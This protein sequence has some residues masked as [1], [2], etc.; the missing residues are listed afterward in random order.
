MVGSLIDIEVT[1]FALRADG[2]FGGFFP[3]VVGP[4]LLLAGG[5]EDFDSLEAEQA[6]GVDGLDFWLDAFGSLRLG[7]FCFEIDAGE[8]LEV[9]DQPGV[10]DDGSGAQEPFGGFKELGNGVIAK[11]PEV[12]LGP[13]AIFGMAVEVSHVSLFGDL[14]GC[15]VP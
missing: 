4:P 8:F 15:G 14:L 11:G 2:G 7:G 9:F 1:G 12:A 6:P 10:E 5:F 3:E 13:A